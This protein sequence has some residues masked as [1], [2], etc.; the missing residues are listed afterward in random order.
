M[1][2]PAGEAAALL[3]ETEWER[4]AIVSHVAITEGAET[5]AVRAAPGEKC[6][7]CWKILPEVGS[8]AAHPTLCGRCVSNLYGAGETRCCA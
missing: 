4:L 5:L 8:V 3:T 2:L 7:R 1:V 6:G